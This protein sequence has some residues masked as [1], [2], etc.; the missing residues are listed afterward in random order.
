MHGNVNKTRCKTCG[1]GFLVTPFLPDRLL[2]NSCQ[3][4]S[5]SSDATQFQ[6]FLEIVASTCSRLIW[7]MYVFV[8]PLEFRDKQG[9]N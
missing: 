7:F 8:F 4:I 3:D 1:I 6:S 2:I 5:L 9:E